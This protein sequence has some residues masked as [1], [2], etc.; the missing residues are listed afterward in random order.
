VRRTLKI[1]LLVVAL[2]VCGA[3]AGAWWLEIG[4]N[5]VISNTARWVARSRQYKAEVLAQPDPT[6]GQLKS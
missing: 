3:L 4:H 5:S 2:L 6:T 1:L